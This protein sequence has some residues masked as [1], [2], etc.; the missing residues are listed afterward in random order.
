VDIAIHEKAGLL[1]HEKPPFSQ[2]PVGVG[3]QATV[4]YSSHVEYLLLYWRG[5]GLSNF[6][7]FLTRF[8]IVK[9]NTILA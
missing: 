8:T 5:S 1:R 4:P 3:S 6:T 7:I 9:L 2:D